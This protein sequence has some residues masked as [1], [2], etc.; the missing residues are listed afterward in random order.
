MLENLLIYEREAFLWLNGHH[1][2]YWD[3]V[4]WLYSGK[5]VWLPVAVFI[6]FVLCYKRDWREIILVLAAIVL[7]ITLCDQFA[8]QV[9]KP[10]FMRFRPTHH[11]DFMEEVKTVFDYRG[12]R[13][14]FISSHAA[15]AF[16]FA[17]LMTLL[18]RNRIL[19]FTLFLW[20]AI[21][22]YSRIYLGVHFLT[23][24]IP[25]MLSGLLFG[26][27]VYR[28]YVWVHSRWFP[29]QPYSKWQAMWIAL[30]IWLM[31]GVLLLF[32]APLVHWLV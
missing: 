6:L 4:M 2:P 11:P 20:A 12:G 5:T 18:F 8:S 10:L 31:F 1:S 23:D 16:G 27:G 22:A 30:A 28:G 25:G 17:M 26:Y 9:C 19:G 13:Y 3:D 21:N 7:T 14:G 24:I 32:H 15:N 29:M